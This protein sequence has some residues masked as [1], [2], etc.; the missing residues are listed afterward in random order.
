MGLG[1]AMRSGEEGGAVRLPN[2]SVPFIIYYPSSPLFFSFQV[3][4]QRHY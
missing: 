3:Q 1:V 2:F 4:I